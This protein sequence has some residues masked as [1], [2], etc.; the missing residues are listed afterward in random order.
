MKRYTVRY[1]RDS[2]GW[3][4]ARV[5]GVQG[6]VTQG[7]SIDQARERV[8]EA[9]SLAIGDDAAERAEFVDDVRLPAEMK[10]LVEA[11]KRAKAKEAKAAVE[12]RKTARTATLA[13]TRRM[14]LSRRDAAA[15]TGYSFQ[16]IQQ[17]VEGTA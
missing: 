17:I 16:R 5:R 13:L 11:M 4:V 3:W 8:R 7:R 2:D 10:R 14:Q 1:D 15:L 9:L 6:V 12:A